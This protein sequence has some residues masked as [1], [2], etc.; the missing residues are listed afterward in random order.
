VLR[1]RIGPSATRVQLL[2]G[3]PLTLRTG[4]GV[5]TLGTGPGRIVPTR[6]PDQ[7]PTANVARCRPATA[8]PATAEP[9][10]AAVDGTATTSWL[11]EEPGTHVTV[12]LGRTVAL[13]RIDITRPPVLALPSPTPGENAITGPVHSAAE[14]IRVSADGHTWYRLARIAAPG[15]H[16]V[17]A[18][19]GQPVRYVRVRAGDDATEQHPLV[20]GDL[21]VR[22]AP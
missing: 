9:A 22:A 13:D 17:V 21:A 2:S 5:Q 4:A 8:S 3:A 16:D 10:E 20:V 12:D 1:I 19:S 7:Q 6:R 15:A 18:G 11:A 14:E